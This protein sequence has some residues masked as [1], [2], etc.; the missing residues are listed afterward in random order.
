MGI[1]DNENEITIPDEI[2]R[3]WAKL[4]NKLTDKVDKAKESAIKRVETAGEP[5][6]KPIK[7]KENK[8]PHSDT[9]NPTFLARTPRLGIDSVEAGA[10]QPAVEEE[11]PDTSAIQ[12]YKELDEGHRTPE[13]FT[14][15]ER[16]LVVKL[17]KSMGKTQDEV[18]M[19]LKVSRRTVVN[20]YRWLRE[21]A[22]L[23]LQSM[24]QFLLGGEVY[25]T[26]MHC[27]GKAIAE[28]RFRTV[29]IVMRDMVEMLQSLGLI[30]RAPRT[31]KSLSLVASA[32][33][34]RTGFHRY[35][36]RIGDEKDEVVAVYDELMRV[37]A[38]GMQP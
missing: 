2:E 29:S 18:A 15:D 22:A 6:K 35:M 7:H 25:E 11:G 30:Y 27:I 28:K 3:D 37:I 1:L 31:Q 23:A 5:E 20:D 4:K 10:G 16:R 13:E 26:A 36:E 12:L 19:M 24:D 34:Q 32:Q 33:L 8:P 14:S 21:Q 9:I 38:N 17:L